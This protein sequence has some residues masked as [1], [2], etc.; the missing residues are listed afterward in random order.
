MQK[1]IVASVLLGA[2]L[3]LGGAAR[4]HADADSLSGKR[5]SGVEMCLLEDCADNGY[6]PRAAGKVFVEGGR[7]VT[8][9]ADF[10]D[11]SLFLSGQRLRVSGA[12][13]RAT[14]S[15]EDYCWRSGTLLALEVKKVEP[16][17]TALEPPLLSLRAQAIDF[18]GGDDDARAVMQ[19]LAC[20]YRQNI[21]E[22][23]LYAAFR[24]CGLAHL[25]AVSGAH[26]VIV[27]GLFSSL[28]KALRVPRRASIAILVGM[29]CAYT[30]LAG[31]PISC[32]RAAIMSSAGVLALFGKRRPSSL[33]ALGLGI[34][35]I[36]AGAPSASISASLALSALSTAGIVMFSPL[37]ELFAEEVLHLHAETVKAPLAMTFS[38]GMLSQLYAS[39]MFC[40]LPLVSPLANVVCAALFPLCCALSL[41]CALAGAAGFPFAG[42][43]TEL[44]LNPIRILNALVVALSKV[45]FASVPISLGSTAAI[46]LTVLLAASVWLAWDAILKREV[47]ALTFTCIIAAGIALFAFPK[48]DSI[49]MLDVGQGDSFLISSGGATLLVDTGNKDRLLLDQL[50]RCGV[51]SLDGVLVTHAD[52]DHCGSLDV[53]EE[54]VEVNTV[55]VARGIS[56]VEDESCRSLIAQ[57]HSTARNVKELGIG[58]VLAIGNLSAEVVWPEALAD[59]GGNAES[60]VLFVTHRDGDDETSD[61]S[62]LFTGDAETDQL[63]TVIEEHDVSDVDMLKVGHHGSR[64]AMTVE[65]LKTLSPRIALIGVGKGNR[66]GHPN[67][68]ILEMLSDM[69]CEVFR[70]DEDGGMRFDLHQG[71]V[72]AHRL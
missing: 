33:N 20:G 71:M 3:A 7:S 26:L 50:G 57:A 21:R 59:D 42:V 25:V 14:S 41:I 63:R 68:E 24:S 66:Y 38:A 27:T 18:I 69:G 22:T 49:I 67:P 10:S 6:L 54:T 39:S 58:D 45:P 64:N 43:L 37:M 46:V 72:E 8:V 32:I 40:Q 5:V 65:E 48:P 51:M 15:S 61:F 9:I 52:D 16:A 53:L 17:D 34:I 70:T 35:A 55:Y 4:A 30:V 29:M 11:G 56:E 62:A 60:L 12:L 1:I 19:A 23:R 2:M 13:K 28:L 47:I 36:V 31:M 44:A